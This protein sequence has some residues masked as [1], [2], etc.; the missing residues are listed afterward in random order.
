MAILSDLKSRKDWK[1]VEKTAKKV[2]SVKTISNEKTKQKSKIQPNGEG[3]AAASELKSYTDLQD[4]LLIYAVNRN[5][6]YVF[7]TPTAQMKIALEM[8]EE[9]DHFMHNEY[10]HFDGKHKR[11]KTFVTLTASVYHLLL[12]KQSVLATMNCKH[13]DSNYVAKFWRTFSE[14]F[15]KA[16]GTEKCFSST[17][18]LSDMASAIFNGLS[19]IYGEEV[20]EREKSCE[21][22]FKQAVKRKIR[23]F[24]GDKDQ[25]KKL[26]YGLLYA[27]APEAYEN[28]L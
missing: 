6:Q 28:S 15:K 5:E 4:P 12:K 8:D 27:T 19:T 18:W 24:D 20:L 22:H 17:S 10:C 21:F 9:G 26:A 7:K 14:A 13:E 16:N 11:G 25:F 3:F 1:V 2:A 23:G